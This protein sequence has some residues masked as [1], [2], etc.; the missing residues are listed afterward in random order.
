MANLLASHTMR[1][2]HR[3]CAMAAQRKFH[4]VVGQRFARGIV[5]DPGVRIARKGKPNGDRGARLR[6]DCG[7]EYE[8]RLSHLHHGVI[9]S[10]GCAKREW[11]RE[12]AATYGHLG[13]AAGAVA[14]ITHGLTSHPLTSTWQMMLH[15][16]ENPQD[17]RWARYGGRGI[18]V[19]DRWHDI[20][21]FVEDIG[22]DLGPRP[23]DYQLDRIDNDGNYEPGNVRWATRLE[24]AANKAARPLRSDRPT[25]DEMR[26]W[27]PLVSLPMANRALNYSNTHG[28]R[29]ARNGQY[30][31]PL[32][33]T[34]PPLKV[35]TADLVKAREGNDDERS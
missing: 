6:C 1:R 17:K 25:L 29:L 11:A 8:A 14:S 18:K 26:T 10:C 21:L 16:C 24:Q 3:I 32:V 33:G 34:Q 9:Q 31:V 23:D 35:R 15:R 5:I 19:C 20:R 13:Q 7:N 22:R 27:E 28:H 4:A 30:P 2:S 12:L